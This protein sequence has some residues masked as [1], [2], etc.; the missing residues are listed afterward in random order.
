[1]CPFD[2]I[3]ETVFVSNAALDMLLLSASKVCVVF[4]SPDDE[5]SKR[6]ASCHEVDSSVNATPYSHI[7]AASCVERGPDNRH[8]YWKNRINCASQE[9]LV[10][11]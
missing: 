8:R 10:G 7:L 9:N 4:L 5:I 11:K 2:P 6:G 1:M 3:L